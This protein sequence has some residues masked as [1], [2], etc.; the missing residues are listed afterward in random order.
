MTQGWEMLPLAE[1]EGKLPQGTEIPI[2][3]TRPDATKEDGRPCPRK[4]IWVFISRYDA[5]DIKDFMVTVF[6][7]PETLEKHRKVSQEYFREVNPE[8]F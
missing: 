3:Y 2:V 4:G 5:E 8:E 7:H 6:N 1:A